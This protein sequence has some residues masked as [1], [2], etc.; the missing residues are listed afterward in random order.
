VIPPAAADAA[1]PERRRAVAIGLGSNVGDREAHL[2]A[3]LEAMSERGIAWT[4]VSSIYE[5]APVGPVRDQTA[6]LNQAAVG[7][8]ELAP[9]ALL[10]VCLAVERERGRVRGDAARWGP[11]TLDL[12][13]LLYGD[14]SLREP[15]L[16][17]PHP[18]MTRRAFVLVPL[19]EVAPEWV[20]PGSGGRSVA[21]LALAVGGREGVLVWRSSATR[22]RT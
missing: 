21:A 11:R 12:D 22:R 20:V 14:A 18:E 5:T 17:V 2:T 13:L 16:E 7:E 4:G 8:T 15:G 6:F 3:G 19:A 1:R 9:R 10:S